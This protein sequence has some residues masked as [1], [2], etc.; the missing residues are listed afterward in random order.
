MPIGYEDIVALQR[1]KKYNPLINGRP[2]VIYVEETTGRGYI[3]DSVNN[4]YIKVFDK[5]S[6][7]GLVFQSGYDAVNN[8]PDIKT[9][10][11][12]V[13]WFWVVT[14]PSNN[15][16]PPLAGG[17]SSVSLGDWLIWSGS[18]FTRVPQPLGGNV[19]IVLNSNTTIS[20]LN[21]TYIVDTTSG[22]ITITVPLSSASNAGLYV[23]FIK[24]SSDANKLSIVPTSPQTFNGLTVL[25]IYQKGESL[26][27]RSTGGGTFG[28]ITED[29]NR[30]S[31]PIKYLELEGTDGALAKANNNWRL[32]P[33]GTTLLFQRYLSG[34]PTTISTLGQSIT[35]DN[36]IIQD[37][38]GALQFVNSLGDS[39]TL[40]K[41]SLDNQGVVLGNP[42]GR[43]AVTYNGELFAVKFD[44]TPQAQ[45]INSETSGSE[46]GTTL[47]YNFKASRVEG[48]ISATLNVV[49]PP[50]NTRCRFTITSTATG[51]LLAQNVSKFDF[52]SPD[53]AGGQ[54]LT[55]GVNT[56]ELLEK[57]ALQFTF[58]FTITFYFTNSVTITGSNINLNDGYGTRFVPTSTFM[59]LQGYEYNIT[60]NG[61]IVQQLESFVGSNR[62]N[63]SAIENIV[64]TV[65]SNLT[66]STLNVSSF[67]NSTLLCTNTSG[68]LAISIND[69]VFAS[70]DTITIKQFAT[71]T[72]TTPTVKITQ[73]N[74]TIDGQTD[75]TITQGMAVTL[76]YIGTNVWRVISTQTV[77]TYYNSPY[78]M[79][80]N[81]GLP[82]TIQT[83]VDLVGTWTG[84]ATL[85]N[86]SNVSGNLV[87]S[88]SNSVTIGNVT[89]QNGTFTFTYTITNTM[90][91]TWSTAST[92]PIVFTLSGTDTKNVVFNTTASATLTP[93]PAGGKIWYGY[94]AT[95]SGVAPDTLSDN[96]VIISGQKDYVD[97]QFPTTTGNKYL[98]LANP[99]SMTPSAIFIDGL[100]SL[101]AFTK[102]NIF[103]VV[104][105]VIFDV[106]YSNNQVNINSSDWRIHYL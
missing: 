104:N 43:F 7:N 80:L 60:T 88:A 16:N 73:T 69:N 87:L 18:A 46:S 55:N 65:S 63:K 30:P 34:T 25:E 53:I 15:I 93:I 48:A 2:N 6:A 50:A 19:P 5:S 101:S 40:V 45:V 67:V 17:I 35:T 39:K 99:Q 4:V 23:A 68:E 105:G 83:Y 54:V 102:S 37:G 44:Q 90:A 85:I 64:N 78:L 91:N 24:S 58:P 26:T 32:I 51:Q 71:T 106:Y 100:N 77:D 72:P 95:N 14:N 33:S 11:K 49:N 21:T 3:W 22:N 74:G 84:T 27:L 62:V 13:G 47:T 59:Y 29:D 42:D 92:N 89:P 97:Y 75:Y 1:V 94:S 36:F 76:Q 10:T 57:L 86:R 79:N 98:V 12:Q 56:L 61:N 28:W 41:G 8:V 82:T 9:L 96:W 38:S 52:D 20:Q 31:E 81:L 70:G 103:P 66:I